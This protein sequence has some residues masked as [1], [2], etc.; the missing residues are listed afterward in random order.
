[1]KLRETQK[2]YN[3]PNM[4]VGAKRK[5]M[6]YLFLEKKWSTRVTGVDKKIM[7]NINSRIKSHQ[8]ISTYSNGSK[9]Q[10]TVRSIQAFMKT[11]HQLRMSSIMIWS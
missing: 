4:I 3:D 9:D 5:E 1:M 8:L 2:V 10:M 6:L 7:T 11:C